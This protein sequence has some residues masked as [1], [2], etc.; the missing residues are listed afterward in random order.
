[1]YTYISIYF[2]FLHY[3][4]IYIYKQKIWA[5]NK[6]IIQ[7]CECISH[8]ILSLLLPGRHGLMMLLFD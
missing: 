2:I 7:H 8:S 1:M 5:G 6:K 4:Y 3:I